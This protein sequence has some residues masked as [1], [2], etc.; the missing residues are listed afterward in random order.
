MS[1]PA[2]TRLG[3][4][5]IHSWLGKGGMGE[6]YLAQDT[7]LDRK[8]ALKILREEA[9]SNQER[10]QRFVQEAK[11]ASALNH[12]NILTIYE[13]GTEPG[14]HFIATEFIDG[15]TLRQHM[16]LTPLTMP[17]AVDIAVQVASAL[18]SAHAA[19]IVH[20]DIK[21]D[22]IM[23]RR[24]GIVKVLDFGLA[25]LTDRWR[26]DEI[27][28]DAA[29]K[30]MVQT[31][32]GVVMGTTAYMSPEQARGLEIDTRTD[33]WSLGVVLYEMISGREPFKSET[34]SDTSAAIL[35]SEPPPLSQ[36][37][38]DPP[39]ELER[40]VRKALQKD[41]EERYQVIKDLLL[42]LKSLK[43]DLEVGAAI[44]YQSGT[45]SQERRLTGPT[46]PI[47]AGGAPTTHASEL[48]QRLGLTSNARWLWLGT[49]L[50]IPLLV[51]GGWY[52]WRQRKEAET[53]RFGALNV[54]KL[55]SRKTDLGESGVSH[56]RFSP[57]GK[58][59]AYA[60]SK[61]GNNSIWLK[62]VGIGEPFTSQ[63]DQGQAAS[64][65]WS[66][67]GLQIAFL[68]KRDTQN[69]IWTMP[70]FGGSPSLLKGLGSFSRELVGWSREGR[71][72]FVMQ[73][74]LYAL[75]VASQQVSQLTQFDPSQP[76]DRSFSVSP[77][78]KRIAYTDSRDGQS[79][80]WLMPSRGGEP[81]RITNDKAEDSNPVWAPDGQRIIYSSKRSGLKQICLVRLDGRA[82]TQLNA[83]DS[84]SE[85]LDVS[86][87]GTK[88]LYATGRDE[89]DLWSVKVD[90]GKESQ[91]TA[92][93]GIELWADI[94]PDGKTIAFQA[95]HAA[96]GATLLNCLLL[97]KTLASDAEPVQ[98][99]P[100]G[101]A[102]RWSPD[103]KRIAFLRY[104][105]GP[106]NL[107][108]VH[109]S[110]GDAKPVTT[111]GATFGGFSLLP[112]NRLETQDFQW[113]EDSTRLTYC[114]TESGVANVWQIAVDGLGATKLSDNTD[115]NALFFNPVLSPDGQSVAWLA[116][117]GAGAGAKQSSWSVW[118]AR[119]GKAQQIFQSDSTLGLV[120]WT[121]S[122]QE[123]IVKSIA[124]K[125]PPKAPVDVSLMAVAITGG[126]P[127]LLAELKATYFANIQLAPARNQVAYVTRR[128]GVDTVEVIP[129]PGGAAKTIITSN[130][131]RVYFAGLVWSP[132]GSALYYARQAGWSVLSMIDN[133]K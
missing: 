73:G 36:L 25:K 118:L 11:A 91:V 65:I 86:M 105:G 80:I 34:A 71:I 94:A 54:T 75:E 103:G 88:I 68:S 46:T 69:G 26:A 2:G 76:R 114:A 30:A 23:L 102:P 27:D 121:P 20:R 133:F 98:L 10:M 72:Y 56:A 61:G 51:G 15:E 106:S 66:P 78:A 21:P 43:R 110:G 131:S 18:S 107:W 44:E 111:G 117:S 108:M 55:I 41:R 84:D 101:Y 119:D 129:A 82:P 13:I 74:N 89:S 48:T 100:D 96:T 64:P 5:E 90:T 79:D 37:V 99:A 92:D 59:I 22:N 109:A 77:D 87:D 19:G 24:D 127:R 130:D 123:L 42:D 40:I 50:M 8:V 17:Q 45:Y 60:A 53:N 31:E 12:P 9:A 120:G 83:N 7:T 29:T 38:P 85:V 28:H 3:R 1:L 81:Q 14:A 97:A 4:Y 112:Y 124:S 52:W 33:V 63:S 49:I 95:T 62:Q 32:P 39:A 128:D 115:P 6:V 47:T 35:K 132:D 67:D 57:D 116:M 104:T 70:A 126:T 93:I 125:T 122:G 16:I 58:F 113:S